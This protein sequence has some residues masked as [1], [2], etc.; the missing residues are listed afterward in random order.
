MNIWMNEWCI[1]IVLYCVLLYTQSALQSCGGLSSTNGCHRTMAAVCSPHT[2]YR[3][4]VERVIEPIKWMG[5]IRG[6]IDKGQFWQFGQ[7]T[8]VTPLLFTRSAMGFWM[9]TESQDLGLTSHLKDCAFRVE[10]MWHSERASAGL[11]GERFCLISEMYVKKNLT[12]NLSRQK[13]KLRKLFLIRLKSIHYQR[14][15]R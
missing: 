3:W 1:Y 8:G 11:Q 9:T 15:Y 14:S 5:I 7:D 13:E 12:P 10:W 6:P 4:R 2:S